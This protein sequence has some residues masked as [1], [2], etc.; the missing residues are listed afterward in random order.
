MDLFFNFKCYI[1]FN[2][3][4]LK[5]LLLFV[6]LFVG[7]CFFY[8]Q[9]PV[10]PN[11][12]GTAV[13]GACNRSFGSPISYT[14]VANVMTSDNV[15]ASA[16]HCACC[17][18]QTDCVLATNFGFAIPAASTITGITVEIEKRAGGFG[19]TVEDNEVQ[20]LKSG[21]EVGLDYR[22]TLAWSS[23]D[24]YRTHG[25]CND[26]WG[27]TWTASDINSVGFGVAFSGIDYTC[28]GNVFSYYDHV[29]ITVCYTA[30]LPVELINFKVTSFDEWVLVNWETQTELNND[31]F[32]IERSKNLRSWEIIG[33]VSG[34]GNSNV[35]LNYNFS[36][37]KPF[38]GTSYYRL[39]QTDFN[40]KIA[41]SDPQT[42]E[43]EEELSSS[44]SPNPVGNELNL[45]SDFL[46]NQY[47]IY[48]LMGRSIEEAR[49]FEEKIDVS[50]L[51]KGLYFLVII[52]DNKADTHKFIKQ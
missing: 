2:P 26:M 43:F 41:Y 5:K 52:G 15:Y 40:G 39:K 37:Y 14:P 46:I 32:T 3:M 20:L 23:F 51:P 48:D 22:S 13:N 33:V 36:D 44:I 30:T 49:D 9:T 8:A 10:G 29:R 42:I 17:D 35:L 38:K 50:R 25:G 21:V 47:S 7:W 1:K 6:C 12:P 4:Q 28:G 19:T 31:Y 24:T 34:N 11:S 27:T 18:A 16:F 45:F